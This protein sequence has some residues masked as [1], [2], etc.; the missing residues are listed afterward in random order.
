MKNPKLPPKPGPYYDDM[1]EI[2]Q[3]AVHAALTFL[4]L[5]WKMTTNPRLPIPIVKDPRESRNWKSFIK[6]CL[7]CE[8][9]TGQTGREVTPREFIR[10]TLFRP[11]WGRNDFM[12]YPNMIPTKW[13]IDLWMANKD[14][15]GQ[16]RTD[17]DRTL[18]LVK[19]LRITKNFLNMR[20]RQYPVNSIDELMRFKKGTIF[21]DAALWIFNGVLTI[22]WC[23]LSKIFWSWLN[24]QDQDVINEYVPM[25]LIQDALK[26]LVGMQD[27]W[28]EFKKIM[29]VDLIDR[30]W[31]ISS[32]NRSRIDD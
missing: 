28:P 27:L 2:E 11:A 13:G 20:L 19:T 25:D 32:I 12:V 4:D 16:E 22:P 7:L 21:P 10:C 5:T 18:D 29:G 6:L 1:T 15:V 9:L 31:A 23:A 30:Q 8:S 3:K 24:D 17:E 14:F 26:K